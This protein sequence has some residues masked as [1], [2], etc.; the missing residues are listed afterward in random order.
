MDDN[1]QPIEPLYFKGELWLKYFGHSN[2]LCARA[3]KAIVNHALIGEYQ[4]RFFSHEEFKCP[5][6]HYSIETRY[7]ILY[8]HRRFNNYW[9][10]RQD[11]ITHFTLFLKFNSSIFSFG[12]SIT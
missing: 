9:N 11:T 2:S 5:C 12:D 3:S 8:K 7:Y 10:L 6:G 1:L 4:L